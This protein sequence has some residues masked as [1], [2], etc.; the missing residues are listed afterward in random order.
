M[1]GTENS[2]S[3]LVTAC[4]VCGDLIN[5]IEFT[6]PDGE[7]TWVWAHGSSADHDPVPAPADTADVARR[8]D[9]CSAPNWEWTIRTTKR[10]TVVAGEGDDGY[11]ANDNGLWSACLPCKRHVVNRD[12]ARL[13]HRAM[14]E[15]RKSFPGE[16]PEFY[17]AAQKE[18][19][20]FYTGFFLAEPGE[21]ERIVK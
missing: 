5:T 13:L 6:A 21:P 7:R 20:D 4:S 15:V 1:S 10:F 2:T 18:I 17:R 12:V 9:F 8:C 11:Q 14:M 3:G 19:R 16:S